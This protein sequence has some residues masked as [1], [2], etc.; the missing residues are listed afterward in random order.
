M[1]WSLR[2]RSF[3]TELTDKRI[4]IGINGTNNTKKIAKSKHNNLQQS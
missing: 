3:E 1:E 4:I 2:C